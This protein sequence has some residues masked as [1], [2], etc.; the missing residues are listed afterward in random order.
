M[1][2]NL[3]IFCPFLPY[4]VTPIEYLPNGREAG[5]LKASSAYANSFCGIINLLIDFLEI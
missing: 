4:S 1:L 5:I 2:I 3:F